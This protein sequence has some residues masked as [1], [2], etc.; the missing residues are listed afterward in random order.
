MDDKVI[1]WNGKI[2]RFLIKEKKFKFIEKVPHKYKPNYLGYVFNNAPQ[3]YEAINEYKSK[4][5]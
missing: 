4:Q 3:I 1:V 5:S 2:A